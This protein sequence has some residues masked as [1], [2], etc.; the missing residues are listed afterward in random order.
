MDEAIDLNGNLR[1]KDLKVLAKDNQ[2]H[3]ILNSIS[4]KIKAIR[5]TTKMVIL[6]Y[7]VM[8]DID[9]IL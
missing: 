6:K 9:I 2:Y 3:P 4:N 1:Y 5:I 7:V 8:I